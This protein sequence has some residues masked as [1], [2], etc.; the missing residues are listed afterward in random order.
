MQ[1]F[2]QFNWTGV[3]CLAQVRTHNIANYEE[4]S[5]N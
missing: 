1:S 5:Q 2:I 3:L 4:Q